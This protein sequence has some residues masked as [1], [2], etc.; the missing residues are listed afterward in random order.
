MQQEPSYVL[1]SLTGRDP[2]SALL[3]AGGWEGHVT[4]I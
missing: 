1:G 2:F 3:E 4:V